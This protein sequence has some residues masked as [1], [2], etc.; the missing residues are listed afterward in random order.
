MI[1]GLGRVNVKGAYTEKISL[2]YSSDERVHNRTNLLLLFQEN[3]VSTIFPP[4]CLLV[5]MELM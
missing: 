1:K 2:Y 3:P 5:P 4:W